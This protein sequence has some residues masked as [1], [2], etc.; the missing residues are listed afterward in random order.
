MIDVA[1]LFGLL[2]SITAASLFFPQAWKSYRTKKT[3]ELSWLGIIIGMLNGIFWIIYGFFRADPFIYATNI[4][5]FL[6]AFLLMIL[7]RKYR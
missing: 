4:I 2:G 7:K 1:S 6:G 5:L 3:Q